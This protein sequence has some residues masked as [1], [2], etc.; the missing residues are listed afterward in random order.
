MLGVQVP[1]DHSHW[2]SRAGEELREYVSPDQDN[3][4]SLENET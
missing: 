2:E 1:T 4:S 3:M